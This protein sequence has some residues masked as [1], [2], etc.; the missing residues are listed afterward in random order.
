MTLRD[1]AV[2]CDRILLRIEERVRNSVGDH[3]PYQA[4]DCRLCG[5]DGMV[6]RWTGWFTTPA[7]YKIQATQDHPVYVR[8]EC[9]PKADPAEKKTRKGGY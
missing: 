3:A 7:G 4:P 8:C 1:L 2:Q 5:D 9:N 6:E